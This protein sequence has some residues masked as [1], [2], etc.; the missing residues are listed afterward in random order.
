MDFIRF[1]NCVV[2]NTS[3]QKYCETHAA[4]VISFV[5]LKNFKKIPLVG[6][7]IYSA[8]KIITDKLHPDRT[9]F[10]KSWD[11]SELPEW[12]RGRVEKNDYLRIMLR[13]EE[14]RL[15]VR[16]RLNMLPPTVNIYYDYPTN[17]FEGMYLALAGSEMFDIPGC[18]PVAL[19]NPSE[20]F[21]WAVLMSKM[22]KRE[23]AIETQTDIKPLV[24]ITPLINSLA[25][26]GPPE[27]TWCCERP[28]DVLLMPCNHAICCKVCKDYFIS[29]E[30]SKMKHTP[31]KSAEIACPICRG[32]IET[33]AK[34]WFPPTN[35]CLL[36][37]KD[38]H[39]LSAVAGGTGGCGCVIGCYEKAKTLCERGGCCPSCGRKLIQVL[40]IFVQTDRDI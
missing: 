7:S 12:G 40:Q 25:E 18:C 3:L 28:I 23:S 4:P 8:R 13:F 11:S 17:S 2:A 33:V 9:V 10:Y 31:N 39:T 34:I 16:F 19:L 5:F 35:R 24:D 38:C 26:V 6:F 15:R 30:R 29:N 27:C 36:C 22:V 37:E 21:K 1:G 20:M 14:K 32:K